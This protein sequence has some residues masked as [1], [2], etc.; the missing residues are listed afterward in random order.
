[1]PQ[2]ERAAYMALNTTIAIT[3]LMLQATELGY[4]TCWLKAFDADAARGI[5]AVPEGLDI[6]AFTPVGR[7]AEEPRQ[8]PRLAMSEIAFAEQ[9]GQPLEA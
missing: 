1:M 8:R 3:Q 6:V 4:G 7:P 9:Y 5:I 2:Q